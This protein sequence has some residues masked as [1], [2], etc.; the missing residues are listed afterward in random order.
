MD[1]TASKR[2]SS[3]VIERYPE[4]MKVVRNSDVMNRQWKKYQKDFDYATGIDFALACNAVT[5]IMDRL[6]R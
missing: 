4:I 2:G 3:A 6:W 5:D 1:A